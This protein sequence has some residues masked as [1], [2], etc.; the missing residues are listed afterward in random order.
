MARYA[1]TE[2]QF[3]CPSCDT[4][5]SLREMKRYFSTLLCPK[6]MG[7]MGCL[8]QKVGPNLYTIGFVY[9]DPPI[10]ITE[11]LKEQIMNLEEVDPVLYIIGLNDKEN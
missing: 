2:D 9:G 6:C 11:E 1:T 5:M 8:E 4:H 3:H 10:Q 7:S